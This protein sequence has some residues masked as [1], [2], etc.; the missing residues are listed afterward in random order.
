[1]A[2]QQNKPQP[3]A[4]KKVEPKKEFILTELIP[5][6][7][8]KKLFIVIAA[9]LMLT[10]ASVSHQYGISGDENFHRVYGHHVVNFYATLGQ[11][12]T[13]ATTNGPDSLMVF[14]GGFYDGTATLLSKALP[15]VNEWNVRHFWNSMFGFFAMLCAALVAV[16][17]AGWQ[18]GL[19]TLILMAFSPRFFGESMNNPKDITMAAGYMVSYLFILKFLKQL[20]NPTLKTAIGLGLKIG[21]A[22]V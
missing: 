4:E 6:S 7:L 9:I 22:H 20:P 18:A 12:T 19:I 8:A 10:M 2:K 5:D 3:K 21:R 16:E 13:A 14:Y 15:S 1:M 11:D 17:V